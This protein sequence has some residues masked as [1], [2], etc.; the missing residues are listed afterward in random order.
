MMPAIHRVGFA[1]MILLAIC[2]A[3]LALTGQL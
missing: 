1:L 3:Y 2:V